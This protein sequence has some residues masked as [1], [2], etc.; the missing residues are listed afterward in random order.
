MEAYKCKD[1]PLYETSCPICTGKYFNKPHLCSYC[2][3]NTY[4]LAYH[5]GYIDCQTA[6]KTF[7][8]RLREGF[9]SVVAFPS[10]LEFPS[11]VYADNVYNEVMFALGQ[12]R[13]FDKG[14]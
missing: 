8:D 12:G 13:Y 2:G 6:M 7:T 11:E 4:P 3:L 5:E 9:K 1:H 10:A 14:Q